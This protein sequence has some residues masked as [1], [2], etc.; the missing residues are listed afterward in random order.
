VGK[1]ERKITLGRPRH[2][3]MLKKWERREQTRFIWFRKETGG[4]I[5]E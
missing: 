3:Y 1:C 2:R 5:F 4:W